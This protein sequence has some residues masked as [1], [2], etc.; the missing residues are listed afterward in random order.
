MAF[1]SHSKFSKKYTYINQYIIDNKGIYYA[2][3]A[4]S[5]LNNLPYLN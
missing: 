3:T 4:Q 1:P 5:I 2:Q